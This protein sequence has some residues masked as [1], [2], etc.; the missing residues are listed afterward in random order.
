[1]KFLIFGDVFGEMGRKALSAALPDLRDEYEPDSVIVNIENI[2]HGKGISPESMKDALS[3]D[4]DVLTTGDHAWDNVKGVEMLGDPTIPVIRPAN[5]FDDVPG[6]GWH[7]YSK[8][9]FRVAVIN[10]QGQ[11][12]FRNDPLNPF[13]TLDALLKNPEINEADII[14]VDFH[15]EATSEHR[16]FGFYADGRIAG[17]FGTH[18]HVPTADA[19][20]LPEGTGYITDIGMV[21]ALDSIIGMDKKASL[22]QFTTQ[23]RHKFEP[24]DSG[25]VE[26]NALLLEVDPTKNKATSI[27]HIR[28]IL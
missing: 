1:M 21:G 25:P 15:T 27:A 6:R 19:Q 2:A 5:Y 23:I 16:G 7:V 18:T 26:L 28:K 17:V 22:K 24:A 14:L 8:G 12:F 20:I 10:M 13:H 11:V 3:W 9:A 4:A